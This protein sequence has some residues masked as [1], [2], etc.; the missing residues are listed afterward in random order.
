MKNIFKVSALALSC[1]CLIANNAI[2]QGPAKQTGKVEQSTASSEP[3]TLTKLLNLS[4][5]QMEKLKAVHEKYHSLTADKIHGLM[6]L[7]HELSEEIDQPDITKE[8]L[9]S[10]QGKIN[11]IQADLENSRIEEIAETHS[12]FTADQRKI[13]HRAK[14]ER[15][16]CHE[17]FFG[18]GP[19]QGPAGFGGPP[20]FGAPPGPGGHCGPMGGPPI[21]PPPGHML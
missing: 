21:G 18:F 12:I 2:A 3:Q 20:G 13:L 1:A 4:E 7:H 15:E 16:V 10:T 6:K 9:L 14:L 19:P 8:T 5:D 17:P 11:A